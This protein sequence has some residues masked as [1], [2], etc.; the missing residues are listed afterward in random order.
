[1]RKCCCA[2]VLTVSF[3]LTSDLQ[4]ISSEGWPRKVFRS[5]TPKKS[6]SV[7]P[8]V[9]AEPEKTLRIYPNPARNF[10]N[11]SGLGMYQGTQ[12]VRIFDITGTLRSEFTTDSDNNRNLPVN[13]VP[14]LYIIQIKSGE[15]IIGVQKILII[16]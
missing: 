9:K 1:M 13:L 4:A 6:T 16:E 5:V 8:V 12:M 3:F 10:I 15:K 11:I 7:K 2:L 14:G